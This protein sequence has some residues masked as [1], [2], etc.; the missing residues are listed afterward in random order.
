MN[1]PYIGKFRVSQCF[2]ANH[3]G[4]D[5]VGV[6]SKEIHSTVYGTVIRAG[7]EN[8]NNQKQGFGL[9]IV[10]KQ[11]GSNKYFYF[12]HLS[13]IFVKVGQVVSVT[14][15]IGIEGNTGNSTGS[16]L[17]YECR[18]NDNK[19]E[20][21]NISSLSGIPN[22]IGTYDDGYRPSDEM[23]KIKIEIDGVTYSGTVKRE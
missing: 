14:Q 21:Q 2:S 17:H 3:T 19:K 7:Y 4:L 6:D 16:H 12:G 5:L 13:A 1:S 8:E 10:I 11:N 20:Y 15:K 23:K 9:R 22:N 18:L